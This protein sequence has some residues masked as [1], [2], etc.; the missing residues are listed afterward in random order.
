[1]NFDEEKAREIVERFGLSESTIKVWKTRGSIPNKYAN[2]DYTQPAKVSGVK[3]ERLEERIKTILSN[4]KLNKSKLAELAGIDLQRMKGYYSNRVRM[5]P[6]DLIEL[7]KAINHLKID[8]IKAVND[9]ANRQVGF[10]V[11]VKRFVEREEVSLQTLLKGDIS[12]YN[13]V[14]GRLKKG[15]EVGTPHPTI[16]FLRECIAEFITELNI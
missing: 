8:A 6:G 4:Q 12:R 7:K 15:T 14:Y 5:T 11:T 10:S 1:M 3:D 2:P 16:A 9:L 13:E